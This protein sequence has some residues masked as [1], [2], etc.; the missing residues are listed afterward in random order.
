IPV[1]LSAIEAFLGRIADPPSESLAGPIQET[2]FRAIMFTD[3]VDSTGLT[4]RLGDMRGLEMI[5]AH[6]SLARRALEKHSGR[7]IKRT[8]D[9]IMASFQSVASA[10]R[11]GCSIQH[12]FDD[13]NRKSEEELKVRIGI[14]A[15]EPVEDDNDLFGVT[16]HLAARVCKAAAPDSV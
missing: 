14:H 10:I 1:D 16:V 3:I 9:G 2:G 7:E 5:R 13:F 8:G 4:A 11:C 12:A 15:G 6:D